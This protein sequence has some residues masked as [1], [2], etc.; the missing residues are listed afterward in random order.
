[1]APAAQPAGHLR[2]A[3]GQPLDLDLDQ[4]RAVG[5]AQVFYINAGQKRE[6]YWI[7]KQGTKTW[8]SFSSPQ[9]YFAFMVPGAYMSFC[10]TDSCHCPEEPHRPQGQ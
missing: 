9:Y 8:I 6:H 7:P 3:L 5:C 1:M 4:Q 10:P 2:E